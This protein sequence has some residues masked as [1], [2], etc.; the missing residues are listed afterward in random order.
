MTLWCELRSWVSQT[1]FT[2]DSFPVSMGVQMKD[3]KKKKALKA[4]SEATQ[5][6]YSVTRTSKMIYFSNKEPETQDMKW[7]ARKL[8]ETPRE[9]Q[10]VCKSTE[11]T[12]LSILHLWS[13]KGPR[14]FSGKNRKSLDGKI[15]SRFLSPLLHGVSSNQRNPEYEAIANGENRPIWLPENRLVPANRLNSRQRHRRWPLKCWLL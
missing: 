8:L 9:L 15:W 2:Q 13:T 14:N 6:T 11:F 4:D 10:R 1:T 12:S 5:G 7:A 3:L